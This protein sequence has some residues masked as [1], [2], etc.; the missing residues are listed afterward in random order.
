MSKECVCGKVMPYETDQ[1]KLFFDMY[2]SQCT[3]DDSVFDS[4]LVY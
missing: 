2:H 3:N 1:D 4:I